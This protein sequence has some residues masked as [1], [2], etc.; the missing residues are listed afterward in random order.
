M[1]PDAFP[2]YRIVESV[3]AGGM[4][5]VYRARDRFMRDVAIKALKP[6]KAAQ[7]RSVAAFRREGE[8]LIKLEHPNLVKG[9]ER[10]DAPA[11]F[12][13]L[14]FMDGET[15]RAMIK[16]L[17]ALDEALALEVVLSAARA[18]EYL[19]RNGLVHRDIKPGNLMTN[20]RG[21]VKLLDLGFALPMGAAGAALERA[22]QTAGTVHYMSPEQAEARTGELDV[23]A[24][25]YSLGATLYHMVVGQVPF[26]GRSTEEIRRKQIR[27]ALSPEALKN[28]SISRP[29]HYFIERMMSK[30]KDYRYGDVAE[31]IRDI[32]EQR[33]G[34]E[35]L[36]H[37]PGAA[38]ARAR[39]P[40]RPVRR[41]SVLDRFKKRR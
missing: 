34:Y 10:G 29:M 15:I 33:A 24:D 23:R 6:E 13:V 21:Q 39:A 40:T 4:S 19:A 25:I 27:E 7:P 35:A 38:P 16:R 31:M 12:L 1:K 32:V 20:R 37:D 9:I 41:S 14:E 2:G 36:Q 22:G 17:G 18:V 30:D 26:A 3:G 5:T 11:P 28:R 8:L